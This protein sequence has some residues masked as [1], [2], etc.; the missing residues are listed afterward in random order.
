M[1]DELLQYID[2]KFEGLKSDIYVR[3]ELGAPYK[4]GT[5]KRIKQVNERVN[6]IFEDTFCGTEILY[7]YIIDWEDNDI[8]FGNTTPNH[9]YELLQEHNIHEIIQFI[10]DKDFDESGNT[11]HIK[12]PYKVKIVRS[13]ISKIPYKEI[14]SGIA[15]YEQGRTPKIGQRVYFID[16]NKNILFNMYDDRGCI[17]FANETEK[18]K[19][20]YLK[21]NTWL[22]EYWRKDMELVF[23]R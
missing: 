3:F 13:I 4:N 2:R 5:K 14:L 19:H 12:I 16:I 9:I 20:L 15:N 21:Y 23:E 6:K 11:I 8:M 10:E 22:D 1:T 18:I 7:I 17:I